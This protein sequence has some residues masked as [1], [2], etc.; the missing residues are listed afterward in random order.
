ML[1]F[2]LYRGALLEVEMREMRKMLA[3]KMLVITMALVAAALAFG[4]ILAI[5]E[6]T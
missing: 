5:A 4:T 3:P 2:S 6:P 1:P